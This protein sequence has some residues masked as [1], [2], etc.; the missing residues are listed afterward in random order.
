MTFDNWYE[1]Q[2]I[3]AE[4]KQIFYVRM[5]EA[6]E[7]ATLAAQQDWIK[8]QEE[9]TDMCI[10]AWVSTMGTLKEKVQR[11]IENEVAIA[12]D[13]AVSSDARKL[14]EVTAKRCAE[15]II[16]NRFSIPNPADALFM[17]AQ[18]RSEFSLSD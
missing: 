7:A 15:I 11:L 13:P 1:A 8:Q 10:V 3:P 5:R 16:E 9:I 18:I 4:S 17:S 2:N 14:Q 6:Y 12:L